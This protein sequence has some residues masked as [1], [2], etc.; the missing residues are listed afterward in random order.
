M[1]Y[2]ITLIF[3]FFIGTISNVSYIDI[4]YHYSCEE[5]SSE[6]ECDDMEE[7]PKHLN[8]SV[9]LPSPN[10]VEVIKNIFNKYQKYSQIHLPI[11][12]PPPELII[13]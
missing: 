5:C 4:D 13:S 12:L 11:P 3:I 6:F 7:E 10:I 1:K 2:I 8:E 9:T